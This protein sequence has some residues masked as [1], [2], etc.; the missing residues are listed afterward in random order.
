MT[1]VQRSV[2]AAA[3]TNG[4]ANGHAQESRQH[5]ESQ[6]DAGEPS[7][8]NSMFE[9]ILDDIEV[10]PYRPGPCIVIIRSR[11]NC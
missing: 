2:A 11:V 9:D 5:E 3:N 7:D 1:P 4:A 8:D 10:N 6:L